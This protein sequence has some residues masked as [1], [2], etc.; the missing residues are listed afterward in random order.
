[1]RWYDSETSSV[2]LLMG[3]GVRAA[4]AQVRMAVLDMCTFLTGRNE[5]MRR[6]VSGLSCPSSLAHVS[7][8]QQA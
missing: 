1:M 5:V 6:G 8:Q 4:D 7:P 3:P 2:P